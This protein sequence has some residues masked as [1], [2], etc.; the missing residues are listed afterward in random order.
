M[1]KFEFST[2]KKLSR[3]FYQTNLCLWI[4]EQTDGQKDKAPPWI[5]SKTYIES[6]KRGLRGS[7]CHNPDTL[8]VSI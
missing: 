3:V 8:S 7:L 2:R 5:I 1:C 6:G 4:D